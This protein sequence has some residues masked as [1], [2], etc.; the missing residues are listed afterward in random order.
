MCYKTL[1]E[2][3]GHDRYS[4]FNFVPDVTLNSILVN[5]AWAIPTYIHFRHTLCY[6]DSSL[7]SG[8]DTITWIWCE[9]FETKPNSQLYYA[10]FYWMA[11]VG[12]LT[13]SDI[14]HA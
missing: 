8:Y 10:I 9:K 4:L 11:Y 6:I 14:F 2:I 13:T 5:G 1:Y 3:M 12:G 7:N